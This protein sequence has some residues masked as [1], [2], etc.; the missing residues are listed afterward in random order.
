MLPVRRLAAAGAAA[1]ACR[2]APSGRAAGLAA[3][4]FLATDGPDQRLREFAWHA[5]KFFYDA[6]KWTDTVLH[7]ESHGSPQGALGVLMIT[8]EHKQQLLALGYTPGSVA[9]M[10]PEVALEVVERGIDAEDFHAFLRSRD[11]EPERDDGRGGEV[12]AE[13]P[14][15]DDAAAGERQAETAL[16]VIAD[17]VEDGCSGGGAAEGSEVGGATSDDG[18]ASGRPGRP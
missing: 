8:R 9:K 6:Q 2:R 11:Q 17:P 12:A 4:R 16:A 1:R 5:N 18:Q 10:K 14:V 13:P 15:D 7:G 3:R